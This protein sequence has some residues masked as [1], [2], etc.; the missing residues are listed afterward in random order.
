MCSYK[1]KGK[2]SPLYFLFIY[3]IQYLGISQIN[4][5]ISPYV[6]F[7]IFAFILFIHLYIYSQLSDRLFND[8]VTTYPY[9]VWEHNSLLSWAVKRSFF[10]FFEDKT[11]MY[12]S[13]HKLTFKN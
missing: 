8:T 6:T 1:R 11:E 13:I 5:L 12:A 7:Y 10:N 3:Y 9:I 2:L 4:N